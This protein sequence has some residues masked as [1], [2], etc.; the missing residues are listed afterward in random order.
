MTIEE[1]EA[2]VVAAGNEGFYMSDA[3]TRKY[4][5]PEYTHIAALENELGTL[6]FNHE[7]AHAGEL[8]EAGKVFLE[9][10]SAM[11][12]QYRHVLRR[13]DAFRRRDTRPIVIGSLPVM[14]QYRLN[15]I[16]SGFRAEFPDAEIIIEESDTK[17]LFSGL[18][19]NFYDAI[20]LQRRM[21]AGLGL[22]DCIPLASDEMA[23]IVR[24]DH[25]LAEQPYIRPRDLKD[26]NF[27]LTDP[28]SA[29]GRSWAF[30]KSNSISTENAEIAEPADILKKI[31]K[32]GTIS[33]LPISTLN[34]HNHDNL[35]AVPM[36]PREG[37]EMVF[38]MRRDM[39]PTR[40]MEQL[41]ELIRQRAKVLPI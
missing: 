8:T 11:I 21:T 27:T 32:G 17:S 33:L 29:F 10:A 31:Q 3:L 30:L 20:I 15:R 6:L 39:I 41:I 38:V 19:D 12:R 36:H 37:V 1:L 34:V 23:A 9:E 40:N 5:S 22:V 26:E 28:A 35:T 13:M 2:F 16:F 25:P 24:N 18:M 4:D 7:G 14:K